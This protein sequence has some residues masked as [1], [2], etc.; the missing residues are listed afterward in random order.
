MFQVRAPLMARGDYSK[1]TMKLDVWRK[2]MTIIADFARQL[3]CRTPLFA[4]TGP[5]YTAARALGG[6]Q[7]TAAVYRVLEKMAAGKRRQDKVR[8]TKKVEK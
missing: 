3:G 1:A 8:S 7:D 2:D 4:A 6:E 5:I